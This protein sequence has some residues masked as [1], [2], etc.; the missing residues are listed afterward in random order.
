MPVRTFNQVSYDDIYISTVFS[1]RSLT[2]PVLYGR[3]IG[4]DLGKSKFHVFELRPSLR[5]L[6]LYVLQCV[7]SVYTERERGRERETT[8]FKPTPYTPYWVVS[9]VPQNI[10][11]EIVYTQGR[12]LMFFLYWFLAFVC[13]SDFGCLFLYI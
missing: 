5:L 7:Y 13:T 8:L 6:S 9:V 1:A 2:C 4:I 11:T 3:W 10:N 12:T